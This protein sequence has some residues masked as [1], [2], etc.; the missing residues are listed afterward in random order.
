MTIFIS[1]ASYRDAQL[2]PTVWDCLTKARYPDDLRFGICWQHSKDE[3]AP[4]FLHDPRFRVM[5]VDW[6]DSQGACCMY[7]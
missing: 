2:V 4:P 7:W 6:Q 1:I 3:L 5:D